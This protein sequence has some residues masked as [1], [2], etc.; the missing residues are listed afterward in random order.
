MQKSKSL[1]ECDNM[2]IYAGILSYT[3]EFAECG[4]LSC[5][6]EFSEGII[7]I[8]AQCD[9]MRAGILAYIYVCIYVYMYIYDISVFLR[10]TT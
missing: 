8:I 3:N 10:V 5:V 6:Y 4:I 7:A 9:N 1:F 2:R